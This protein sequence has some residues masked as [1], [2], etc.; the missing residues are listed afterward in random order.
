MAKVMLSQFKGICFP[1]NKKLANK[2]VTSD[3]DALAVKNVFVKY[4]K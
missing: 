4:F 3:R 2:K 1:V